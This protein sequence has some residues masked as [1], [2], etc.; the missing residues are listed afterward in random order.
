MSPQELHRP[1]RDFPARGQVGKG[2]LQVHSQKDQRC[3]CSVCEQTFATTRGTIFYRLRHA[4]EVAR[5]VDY[6]AGI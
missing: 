5:Q 3:G 4:L 1:N 6:L 2:N